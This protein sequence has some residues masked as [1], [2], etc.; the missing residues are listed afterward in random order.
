MDSGSEDGGIELVIMCGQLRFLLA[1]LIPCKCEY[2]ARAEWCLT[3]YGEKQ[4]WQCTAYIYCKFVG[5]KSPWIIADKTTIT[6]RVWKAY[7]S[8]W[9]SLLIQEVLRRL[10]NKSNVLVKTKKNRPQR[11]SRPQWGS[12]TGSYR[13]HFLKISLWIPILH[14]LFNCSLVWLLEFFAPILIWF[15]SQRSHQ[16]CFFFRMALSGP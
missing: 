4:P 11:K 16:I 12:G 3:P 5:G 9:F 1:S 8:S 10:T 14:I 15:M 2:T 13:S 6:F 7:N